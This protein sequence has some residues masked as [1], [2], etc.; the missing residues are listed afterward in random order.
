MPKNGRFAPGILAEIVNG[1]P[2]IEVH[3][4]RGNR[5][6]CI[7]RRAGSTEMG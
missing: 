4:W 1:K 6:D 7:S 3:L 5:G 2:L